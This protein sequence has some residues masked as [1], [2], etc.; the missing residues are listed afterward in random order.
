MHVGALGSTQGNMIW[1]EIPDVITPGPK[2]FV[3]IF[4]SIFVQMLVHSWQSGAETIFK[5]SV[6][7]MLDYVL[8]DWN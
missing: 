7:Y 6:S 2:Y 4:T 3:Q 1:L 8:L 5:P